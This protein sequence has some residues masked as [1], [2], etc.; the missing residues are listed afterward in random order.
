ME[1]HKNEFTFSNKSIIAYVWRGII[2]GVVAGVMVSLFRLVIE[3]MAEAVIESYHAAHENPLLFVPIVGI[4]LLAVIF[5]GFLVKSDPD[6]KGSGI[7]HVEGELKGLLLPNWWSILWKKFLGGTLAISMGFMLGRE[8]PS[9]QLGAMSAKGFAKLIK[10]SRLEKRVLIASGAAAG[11]SAAFNA[12]IAGLL[13]VV[14]EIYHHFSRLIWITALVASLVANFISLNIFGLKPV[15]GMP[16]AMPFL[17]LNQYWLLLL[18]GL[19]LGGLGYLY[20][21][22]IL[23][24]H[25]LYGVLGRWLHLPAHFYGIILVV[26]IL[27]IGYYLPQLLG[28]GMV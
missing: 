13:F 12:P 4:S 17:G 11:L 19:F 8:G 6:I 24:F 21:V 27:P 15:L 7:P 5:V 1:N 16:K 25:K 2:V 26:M 28:G 20:E 22:V 23:D 10:S 3:K 18:L 9:I 14:E